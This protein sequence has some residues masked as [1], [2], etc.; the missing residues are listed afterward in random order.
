MR[1]IARISIVLTLSSLAMVAADAAE[2]PAAKLGG[3]ALRGELQ[4]RLDRDAA[5][6]NGGD[7]EAFCASYA[8]DAT[9]VTP[10]G[11]VHGRA[12]VLARYRKHYPDRKAMGTLK[13]EILEVRP[14]PAPR[15]AAP[16]AVSLVAHW[17]LDYPLDDGHKP[18]AAG[19]TLLVL[20][21]TA[22]GGWEIVQDAS[23]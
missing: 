4:A 22:D 12:E 3:A 20:H 11:I 6:W 9:F 15:G 13:L 23:M 10:T 17:S 19:S 21:R 16:S 8:A 1:A 2:A 18:E 14:A 5:A 7:L